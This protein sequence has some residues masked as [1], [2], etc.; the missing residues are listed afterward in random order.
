MSKMIN[1]SYRSMLVT[2]VLVATTTSLAC[3]Y[4]PPLDSVDD[5][6]EL[7]AELKAS[8][9]PAT[10]NGQNSVRGVVSGLNVPG[11]LQ[12]QQGHS[13]AAPARGGVF[14]E[15]VATIPAGFDE[16]TVIFNGASASYTGGDHHVAMLGSGAIIDVERPPGQLR[17]K[18]AGSLSDDN[19]DDEFEW[20]YFYSLLF[21]KSG[22]TGLQATVPTP[23]ASR[24][25]GEF[26]RPPTPVHEI[27]GS[28]TASVGT[29]GGPRAVLP[30]GIATWFAF[31]QHILQAGF[32]LGT[33]AISENTISWTSQTLLKDKESWRAMASAELVEVMNGPGVTMWQPRVVS[34][35]R[36]GRWQEEQ[37]SFKLQ[38][39]PDGAWNCVGGNVPAIV[40]QYFVDVPFAY[41]V[42]L[43]TGWQLNQACSDSHVQRIGAYIDHYSFEPS[44]SGMGGILKYTVVGT[45]T[46]DNG[47]RLYDM[48]NKV[49]ILGLQSVTIHRGGGPTA[50]V[51]QAPSPTPS[52]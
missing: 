32:D 51:T 27:A 1:G 12:V 38:A 30:L 47:G 4:H 19:A 41:A 25:F 26:I 11:K 28:I 21:W 42:P 35:W 40:E 16:A 49:T 52:R 8:T 31:D 18:A 39:Q 3:D 20:C 36:N 34:H 9:P 43:L 45:L 5:V 24:I 50:P 37:V 2:G 10:I 15:E 13:C 46:D 7:L 48:Q 17:W 14:V 22:A 29:F 33:P 6:A 44:G 23:T